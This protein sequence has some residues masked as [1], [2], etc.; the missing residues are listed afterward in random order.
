MYEQVCGSLSHAPKF[1]LL[2][3]CEMHTDTLGYTRNSLW[4]YGPILQ[5]YSLQ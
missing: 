3:M 1:M 2:Y 5:L 4:C